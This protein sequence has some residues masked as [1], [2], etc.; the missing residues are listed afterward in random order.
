MRNGVKTFCVILPA[1]LLTG[2]MAETA[3][4]AATVG[5]G[6]AEEIRQ[7]KETMEHVKQQLDQMNQQGAQRLKDAEA[8]TEA[9]P[10]QEK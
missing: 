2:C 4:T 1:A 10:T 3:S 8:A 7:G 5:A 6:K 9:P